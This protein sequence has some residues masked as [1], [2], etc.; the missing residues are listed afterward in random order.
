MRIST[1]HNTSARLLLKMLKLFAFT[2][3]SP[4]WLG[5]KREQLRKSQSFSCFQHKCVFKVWLRSQKA[6]GFSFSKQKLSSYFLS[7]KESPW[8]HSSPTYDVFYVT[9]LFKKRFRIS[10]LP[11]FK[12]TNCWLFDRTRS[13]HAIA[14]TPV[15][16]AVASASDGEKRN[17]QVL[18]N[19]AET[20]VARGEYKVEREVEMIETVIG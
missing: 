17:K 12:T 11:T 19:S 6:I 1:L 10:T 14:S 20:K 9:S 13:Q 18:K 5:P 3:V 7:M 2:Y 16:G 15:R 8:G 4:S